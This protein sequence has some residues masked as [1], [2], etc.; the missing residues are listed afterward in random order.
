VQKLTAPAP[1]ATTTGPIA[2]RFCRSDAGRIVLDLGYQPSSEL[3]PPVDDRGTDAVYPLRMWLCGSCGL[4]QLADGTVVP[5]EVL[6]REPAALTE[7]RAAAV[8]AVAAAGVLPQGGTVMEYPSPHGGTW[9]D[10]LATH[11]FT[12]VP[13]GGHADVVVDGCFGL[14]HEA[15]QRAALRVRVDAVAPG[16]T[17]VLL[18]HSLAAIMDGGQWNALRLGH[19][20]YYSTPGMVGMLAELGMTVTSAHRF[21]LYGGTVVL[22]ASRDAVPDTQ[23]LPDLLNAERATGVLDADA[24]GAL[25]EAVGRTVTR[26]RTQ[27]E[28]HKAAGRRVYGYAAA[29]RAVS[30]LCLVGADRTLL[31]GVADASPAKRGR[32]MPGTDVP[33]IAP[34][35][36]VAAEPDV[37]LVFVSDVVDE[38]RRAL[39]QIPADRWVDAGA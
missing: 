15:D 23:A 2:C 16:G 10:G 33:V 6:G 28:E 21:P 17:L 25:G 36:L 34:E 37:V 20:A 32:R 7:Q 39:P 29:S 31:A 18:Y 30:L 3:F 26:L 9:L 35:Q 1:A 13:L 19:F 12:P 5:E 8:T 4:A 38:V 27:L 24:V 22:T 14:M 11:G